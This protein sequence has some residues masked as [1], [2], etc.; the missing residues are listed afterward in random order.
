[1]IHWSIHSYMTTFGQRRPGK[2]HPLG[3]PPAAPK[4]HTREP[5]EHT[6]REAGLAPGPV[7]R[8]RGMRR[9]YIP[10]P[11]ASDAA[12]RSTQ[13][14][15]K[16]RLRGRARAHVRAHGHTPGCTHGALGGPRPNR[17]GASGTTAGTYAPRAGPRWSAR[18]ESG[19][20]KPVHRRREAE[21]H[22]LTHRL[23]PGPGDLHSPSPAPPSFP[24]SSFSLPPPR[25]RLHR[26]VR[27]S[28][29]LPSHSTPR[30]AGTDNNPAIR[31]SGP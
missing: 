23:V 3:N 21:S 25:V 14:P 27:P 1:M 17:P 28:R 26:P 29:H 8:L 19:A 20:T 11:P 13:H 18:R 12:G 10:Q 15:C 30:V 16:R 7:H 2:T 4:V 5:R 31:T 9:R 6:V 22:T 24:R